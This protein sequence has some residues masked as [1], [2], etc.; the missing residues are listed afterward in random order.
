MEAVLGASVAAATGLG[1]GASF[2]GAHG[3][4]DGHAH[5]AA[6]YRVAGVLAPTGAVIDRLILTG[7]ESVWQLHEE[8]HAAPVAPAQHPGEHA[9]GHA[10]AEHGHEHEH[11]KHE[12]DGHDHEDPAPATD[13]NEA[14]TPIAP[15]TREITAMLL[16]YA[17]PIAAT[18]LPREVNQQSP[19]QAAAPAQELSRL[20]QRLGTGLDVLAGFAALLIACAALSIFAALYGALR[21]RR[22][23]VAV[24]RCL[25]AT[26][27]AVLWSLLLEGL[28]LTAA[29]AAVGLAL[30]H[31]AAEVI[32]QFT[33][34]AGGLP[35]TGL[36]WLPEEALLLAGLLLLGIA[37]AALPA[38][39]ACRAEPA[40]VLA[41]P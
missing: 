10:A 8:P 30:G 16:R 6:P 29:G 9:D 18:T 38:W 13:A 27:G 19:L 3:L 32:G 5:E 14:A 34:A 36:V 33:A 7:A 21:A 28:L 25:G 17:S 11:G 35:L 23:A 26:R 39:Q 37:A 31:G 20:L 41:A 15:P 22:Q 12:H 1:V 2:V 4:T 40:T 24:L